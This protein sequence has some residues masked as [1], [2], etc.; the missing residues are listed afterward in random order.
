[1]DVTAGLGFLKEKLLEFDQSEV[2]VSERVVHELLAFIQSNEEVFVDYFRFVQLIRDK[3]TSLATEKTLLLPLAVKFSE[4]EVLKMTTSSNL[5]ESYTLPGLL[6]EVGYFATSSEKT[7]SGILEVFRINES[8]VAEMLGKMVRTH[9][10]LEE[11]PRESMSK[12]VLDLVFGGGG[13]SAA[14]AAPATNKPLTGWDFELVVS[15]LKK[16]HAD[17]N[18]FGV[19]N[20]FD[21]DDFYIPD[22]QAFNTLISC[23][24]KAV[25]EHF[26]LETVIGRIWRN[27]EGQLSFLRY[28]VQSPPEV[29][30]FEHSRKKINRLEGIQNGKTPFGTPNHA[31]LCLDLVRTLCTLGEMPKLTEV[32][33]DIIAYPLKHCQ[34]VLLVV[35][36]TLSPEWGKIQREVVEKLLPVFITSNPNT[37]VVLHR[38]W[39]THKDKMTDYIVKMYETDSSI[40]SRVLDICQELKALPYVLEKVPHFMAADMAS[41]AARRECLNLDKWLKDKISVDGLSFM[42][43]VLDFLNAKLDSMAVDS[44]ALGSLSV[45]TLDLYIRV[46][47]ANASALSSDLSVNVAQLEER[48]EQLFPQLQVLSAQAEQSQVFATDIEEKANVYFHRIYSEQTRLEDVISM[49]KSYKSSSEQREQEVFACM[50]H[51]LFDEYRFFPNY[52]ERALH[53]TAM[54]FG[55]LIHHQLV[56]SITLGIALRYVM[57]ALK[58]PSDSSM[59]KFGLTAINQ[60]KQQ[61]PGWPQYCAQVLQLSPVREADPELIAFIESSLPN[62]SAPAHEPLHNEPV[63]AESAPGEDISLL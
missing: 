60:F 32:V 13:A 55:Q 47:K 29:F 35:M 12:G 18:W 15:V 37:F 22:F 41:L 39:P 62:K 36:A 17:L 52:P 49:L 3:A 63:V 46:L 19:A 42:T 2:S 11:R 45:E 8:T 50:V 7:F 30:T 1:M 59:F 27:T 28:A 61:L 9:K 57:D 23:F 14:A 16:Q 24:K 54:L 10:G 25:Q 44:S 4:R 58:K 40:M 33:M 21:Y 51:N 38:V 43:A 20:A 31:W 34:E 56:S 26:P 48:A 5:D 6:E 53:I